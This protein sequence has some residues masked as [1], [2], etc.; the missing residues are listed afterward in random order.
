MNKNI[1]TKIS[2]W[3]EFVIVV[4]VMVAI[5]SGLNVLINPWKWTCKWYPGNWFGNR[6]P[7]NGSAV[8]SQGWLIS[9]RRLSAVRLLN[10]PSLVAMGLSVGYVTQPQIGWHHPFMIGWSKDRLGLPSAPLHYGLTWPVGIPTFFQPPVTVPLHCPNN[11]LPLV[12]STG[13]VRQYSQLFGMGCKVAHETHDKPSLH[14]EYFRRI[15]IM[16]FHIICFPC[17]DITQVVEILPHVL[18]D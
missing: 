3:N 7:G 11:C 8:C 1:Y 9:W 4:E 2:Q 18:K 16:Y 5:C 17:T 12:L 15:T 10:S 14:A 13:T 6:P